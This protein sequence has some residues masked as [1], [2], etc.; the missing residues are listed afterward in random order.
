[1]F[2]AAYIVTWFIVSL[3][4]TGTSSAAVPLSSSVNRFSLRRSQLRQPSKWLLP[5]QPSMPRH[6]DH[7][8]P[9]DL[10]D[11]TT[12]HRSS[13]KQSDRSFKQTNIRRHHRV[14]EMNKSKSSLP[15][16]RCHSVPTLQRRRMVVPFPAEHPPWWH[17]WLPWN[18]WSRPDLNQRFDEV[19]RYRRVS[20]TA[21]PQPQHLVSVESD[22]DPIFRPDLSGSSSLV[23][24]AAAVPNRAD[25]WG[26]FTV[27]SQYSHSGA[28]KPGLV[29]SPGK[30]LSKHDKLAVNLGSNSG[31]SRN[32]RVVKADGILYDANARLF[33]VHIVPDKPTISGSFALNPADVQ[34]GGWTPVAGSGT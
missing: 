29:L 10:R 33:D 25:E 9:A 24:T 5:P 18:S 17:S 4:Q 20:A 21:P 7:A 27:K 23:Q 3:N 30:K 34:M 26:H 11:T 15:L 13:Y 1:M 22:H 32:S 28:V 6:D 16:M 2:W 12:A 8:L 19:R 31:G 14:S